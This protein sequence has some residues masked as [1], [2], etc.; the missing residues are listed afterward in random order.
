MAEINEEGGVTLTGD[1]A[2][3]VLQK[4]MDK[5]IALE[6][7]MRMTKHKET[8]WL[9]RLIAALCGAI[10]ALFFHGLRDHWQ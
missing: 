5:I 7:Q 6:I 9:D 1:D 2:V 10:W 4:M 8:R 3:V